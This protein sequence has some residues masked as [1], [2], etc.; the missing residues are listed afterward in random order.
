MKDATYTEID[1]ALKNAQEAFLA[2]R[3][4]SGKQKANLLRT[5]AAEIEN[6][7]SELITIAMEES[8]LPEARL[9]GERGRTTG[10]LK[11]FAD[12]LEEGSWVEASIDTAIPDRQPLPKPDLRKMLFPLGNIVVFG[13]SNF[14]LAF[15]TAGGDTASALAA[16][17]TVVVKAHPAH[18]ETSGLVAKAIATALEKCGL[19]QHIFTHLYGK[20]IEVGKNLVMHP[21]TNAVAF[22]GSYIGGKALFDLASQ[23]KVPIPVFAEMGSINPVLLLPDALKSRAESIAQQLANSIT[24]SAGQFC[25]KAGILIGIESNELTDF[26]QHLSSFISQIKPATMLYDGIANNYDY[27][28]KIALV[29]TGVNLEAQSATEAQK[30][31]AMPT[32]ASV[33]AQDFLKNPTLHEEVFGAYALI[34]K[35][36]HKD[37]MQQ[38]IQSLEG[39]LTATIIAEKEELL[40]HKD[41]VDDLKNNVGRIIINGV[42]TGVEVC[43]SM[44][45]GGTFPATTDAH[46]TSV[47]TGA[48]KRFV[49]PICLQNFPDEL[50]PSELQASNPLNIWRLTNGKWGKD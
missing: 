8:H 44:Q 22:T 34:I 33:M 27:Q 7:G 20:H 42:P 43:H 4:T 36:K 32:I 10:Q 17:C 29:Q 47:G 19:P 28:R 1:E 41:L 11:L 16:G 6:L 35:C 12:L 5:I 18:P 49:R 9:L 40:K 31:E 3:H 25:T 24:A 46:F 15:S 23:R 13:A 38:I 2:Y 50:L 48:I 21:L 30:D 37:E 45:H 39:Q 14:P 26:I